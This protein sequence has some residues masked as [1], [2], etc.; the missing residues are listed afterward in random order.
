[1]EVWLP[2]ITWV[3]EIKSIKKLNRQDCYILYI[4]PQNSSI[5]AQ[6][7]IYL[8]TV[9]LRV[10]RI[11]DIFPTSTGVKKQE[12]DFDP[13]TPEPLLSEGSLVPYDLPVF[14]L[15]RKT[16]Q[17]ADGFSAY[18][19]PSAKEFGKITKIGGFKFKKSVSQTEKK[20]DKQH[21]DVFSSYRS[22]GGEQF[23]IELK[24]PKA[25]ETIIQLWQEGTP[26]ALLSESPSKVVRF[27][28]RMGKTQGGSSPM[29]GEKK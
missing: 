18:S 24:D 29:R 20:P 8:S 10:F 4:Y 2:P 25:N 5:R 22:S 16:V 6:A 21:A 9:D 23:Q 28:G 27:A 3:F 14:P 11:I 26:W 7:V 17:S 13:N 19:E 12:R 15:V 1:G